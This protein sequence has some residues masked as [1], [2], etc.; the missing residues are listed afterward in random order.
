MPK[1]TVRQKLH[2]V[3]EM[4]YILMKKGSKQSKVVEEEKSEKGGLTSTSGKVNLNGLNASKV[5]WL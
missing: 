2:T 4:I 3:E 5:S 1:E